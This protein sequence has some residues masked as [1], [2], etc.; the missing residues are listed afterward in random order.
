M[1]KKCCIKQPV[2]SL[3]TVDPGF[4]WERW[5]GAD[6]GGDTGGDVDGWLAAWGGPDVNGIP[7]H[8]NGDPATLSGVETDTRYGQADNSGATDDSRL[9][10]WVWNDREVPIELSDTDGRA[11]SWRIYASCDCPG[12]LIDEQYQN[13][14]G[15]STS[16][17]PFMTVPPGGLLKLTVLIHD[18][19]PDF[20]GFWLRGN[21][22]GDTTLFNPTTFQ[23]RP[24][25]G[26]EVKCA[27]NLAENESLI[28]YGMDCVDC[29]G[30][31][32]LSADDVA[33]L[34]PVASDDI[35]IPDNELD[36]AIRT[37]TAGVSTEFAR[38]DHNHPIR[39]QANPGDIVPTVAGT[40]SL[41]GGPL[42]LDRWAEEE[43]YE[44]E[45]RQR[46]TLPAGTGWGY[47]V[48][49]ALP[50]WSQPKITPI[51]MYRINSTAVQDDDGTFGASPRGPEMD[52]S[53]LFHWS[54]TRRLYYRLLRR[55]NPVDGYAI[56]RAQYV[57]LP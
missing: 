45:I 34:L 53:A 55:D 22:V 9:C 19:G 23:A 51:G 43:S 13:D 36:T 6:A 44:W 5:E 7:T 48:L 38:A 29:G 57:R 20:S 39:V 25:I 11:E 18:P 17:G 41:V 35:P 37:G 2:Y 1:A 40:M 46:V 30:S 16:Q 56:F 52:A 21:E 14:P 50:G 12:T 24:E 8:V 10:Y 32:G 47:L 33:A 15:P 42:Y 49:P 54:S 28:P 3:P 27:C 26:V 31:A 4:T